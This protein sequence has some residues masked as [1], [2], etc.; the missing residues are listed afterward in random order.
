M[1]IH[2]IL[3]LDRRELTGVLLEA[4]AATIDPGLRD[5]RAQILPNRLDELR[6]VFLRFEDIGIGAQPS[7]C[8]VQRLIGNSLAR[9]LGAKSLKPFRET[10]VGKGGRGP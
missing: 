8:F 1:A 3:R 6:L 2:A 4:G 7:Q 10:F 5:R 9:G